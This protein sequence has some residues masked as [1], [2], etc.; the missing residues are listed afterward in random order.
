VHKNVSRLVFTAKASALVVLHDENDSEIFNHVK[1][2]ATLQRC[3]TDGERK[4]ALH[5]HIYE[6]RTR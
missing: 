2:A 3:V 6:M 1:N 4:D 5:A